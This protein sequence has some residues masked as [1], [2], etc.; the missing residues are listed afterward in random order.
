[1]EPDLWSPDFLRE[2]ARRMAPGSRLSTYSASL[3]VRAALRAAGLKVGPGA[4]V[5]TKSSGTIASPDLDP[6]PFDA[7]T[8]RRVEKRALQLLG[9]IQRGSGEDSSTPGRLRADP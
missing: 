2:V 5:G 7:R 6:G 9:L 8:A 1:V 4:R 3:S